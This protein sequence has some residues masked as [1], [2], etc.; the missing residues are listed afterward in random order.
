M[1]NI[2]KIK[3]STA[4]ATP[5]TLAIGELAYSELSDTLFIGKSNSTVI[6]LAG[7]G[8]FAKLASPALTG[9]PTAPTASG[10]TNT[11]QL[12]T[13]AFVTGALASYLTTAVATA[14]YATIT[15]P[16]LLGTP[17]APTAAANTNTTQLATT[18]FVQAALTAFGTTTS[19]TYAPLASPA[20][21]GTPTAPT[22]AVGTSTTQ[23]ATT[24]FVQ[25][26]GFASTT[27]V[28]G[29]ISTIL[30]A[31]PETLDT[32]AEIDNA[33]NNDPNFATTMTTALATKLVK[34]ANLSDLAS[35][36]TARTNL[37]LGSIATQAA[38]FVAITGGSITS[39]TIDSTTIDGGTF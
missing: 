2:I 30:G 4:T 12:A 35:A 26:A 29:K 22:A 19:T 38:N 31:A 34:T 9:I 25:S 11:T 20:L 17:T 8:I 21:T 32:L 16:G 39:V 10:G 7:A 27:Y 6:A 5:A 13:T 3:R 33:L 14:T 15:S 23:I 36:A 18:A 1:A 28:D 24:A 37:G